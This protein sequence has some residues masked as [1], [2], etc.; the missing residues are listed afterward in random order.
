MTIAQPFIFIG[1]VRGLSR[2]ST[3]K[4]RLQD[5]LDA[6]TLSAALSSADTN[7]ALDLVGDKV[8]AAQLKASG[9]PVTASTATF[10]I[11]ANGDLTFINPPDFENPASAAGTNTYTGTT[12]VTTGTLQLNDGGAISTPPLFLNGG[13][14]AVNRTGT[15]TLGAALAAERFDI[16][17]M[18]VNMPGLDGREATRRLRAGEGINR[19]VPII[20]FSAVMF[21]FTIVNLFFK[22]LHVYSGLK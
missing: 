14:F 2:A 3:T 9:I 6:A 19:N 18:D 1:S 12:T 7:A 5:G 15:T 16:V 20:G 8:L 21:N 10:T 22:G 13:T 17:L 4:S 11:D